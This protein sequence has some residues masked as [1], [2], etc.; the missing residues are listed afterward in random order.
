MLLRVPH[1][2]ML[3]GRTFPAT[4]VRLKTG[5]DGMATLQYRDDSTRPDECWSA[6]LSGCYLE[7][8]GGPDLDTWHRCSGFCLTVTSCDGRGRRGTVELTPELVIEDWP[9]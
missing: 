4:H 2:D 9:L 5:Q 6:A 8:D 7:I 3:D 1:P